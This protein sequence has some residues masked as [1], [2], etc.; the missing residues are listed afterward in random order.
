[1]GISID[2][3]NGQKIATAMKDIRN[4]MGNMNLIMML[5]EDGP[6]YIDAMKLALVA[7]GKP[8]TDVFD[9]DTAQAL[10]ADAINRH[11]DMIW[12]EE[13]AAAGKDVQNAVD[14]LVAAP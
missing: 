7:T 3:D 4:I 11:G 1:M 8:P 13:V 5:A 9:P 6:T 2:T 12:V 14:Y 10:C